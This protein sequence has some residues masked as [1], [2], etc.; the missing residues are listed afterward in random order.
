MLI[1]LQAGVFYYKLQRNEAKQ[2][3]ALAF[4]DRSLW[5]IS[6]WMLHHLFTCVRDFAF[7]WIRDNKKVFR[8]VSADRGAVYGN[9]REVFEVCNRG[10]VHSVFGLSLREVNFPTVF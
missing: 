7:V 3:E 10:G 6:Y 5:L 4:R 8:V 1:R 9:R 2:A